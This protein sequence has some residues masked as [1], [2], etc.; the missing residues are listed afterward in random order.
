M[1]PFWYVFCVESIKDRKMKNVL[2]SLLFIVAIPLFNTGC[3][4][5]TNGKWVV[6]YEQ[7][8]LPP[9]VSAKNDRR[10]KDN[11]VDLLKA[12]GII[13]LKIKIKGERLENLDCCDCLTGKEYYVQV[14]KSQMSY[15][16][17]YGFVSE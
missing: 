2:F 16:Y 8:C 9:W 14:D 11:L 1:T 3:S 13:P 17:Y 6:Y 5:T 10:T 4:K 7:N 15:M 12:D